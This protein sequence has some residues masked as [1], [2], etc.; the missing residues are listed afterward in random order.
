MKKIFALSILII[1]TIS[2]CLS[3][4]A[5]TAISDDSALSYYSEVTTIKGDK[6]K[7]TQDVA[8]NNMNRAVVS[9]KSGLTLVSATTKKVYVIETR[10]QNHQ[11]INSRLMNAN[12]VMAYKKSLATQKSTSPLDVTQTGLIGEDSETKGELV[13]TLLVYKDS[14]G[15]YEAY[16]NA[17]WTNGAWPFP[18]GYNR[19][20]PGLDFIALTWGGEGELK[21]IDYS[22]SGYYQFDQG[23]ISFSRANSDTYRGYCWQFEDTTSILG[24]FYA[25]YINNYAELTKT[26]P[27]IKNKETNVKL[28]YVH[29]YQSSVGTITFTGGYNAAAAE[30]SLSSTDK[31][32]QIEVDVPSV[33][34]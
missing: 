26:Y 17:D 31:Q 19:P 27:S 34:Y 11:V 6:I 8:L 21:C 14:I 2:L 32:W 24:N 9:K 5:K 33:T 18:D 4:S 12:E 25:D 1:M 23:A 29:T 20:G 30:V 7:N 10:D 28:T 22:C 16:G 15:N 3:T 13:I